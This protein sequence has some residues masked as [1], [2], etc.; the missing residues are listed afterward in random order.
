MKSPL[1][2]LFSLVLFF[3]STGAFAGDQKVITVEQLS[4]SEVKVIGRLGVP[5]GEVATLE[6][7]VFDGAE[8]GGKYFDGKYLLKVTSVNGVTMK[9]P[10]IMQFS[11]RDFGKFNLS[12]KLAKGPFELYQIKHGRKT[13]S[14]ST[15]QINEL[16]KGYIGKQFRLKA[17]ETGGFQGIPS[18]PKEAS[19]WADV[20]FSFSTSLVLLTDDKESQAAKPKSATSLQQQ[21]KR[22]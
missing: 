9:D 1:L 8:L 15:E 6:V 4:K 16:K 13:G 18:L 21:S 20:G 22:G 19:V 12:K 14:L 3:F 10:P 2:C 11:I 5:L 17:Y 7:T